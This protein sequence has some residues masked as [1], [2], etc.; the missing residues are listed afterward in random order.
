MLL[1]LAD[2]PDIWMRTQTTRATELLVNLNTHYCLSGRSTRA[3][4]CSLFHLPV[5]QMVAAIQK[6]SMSIIKKGALTDWSYSTIS[7]R[8]ECED[9][10]QSTG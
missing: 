2:I 9:H 4:L 5:F 10:V 3:R 1:L 7:Q 8:S 6:L